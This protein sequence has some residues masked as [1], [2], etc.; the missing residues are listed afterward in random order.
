MTFAHRIKQEI[1][2]NKMSID[3]SKALIIGVCFSIGYKKNNLYILK[4]KN[5]VISSSIKKILKKIGISITKEPVAHNNW[6]QFNTSYLPKLFIPKKH[7]SQFAA[8][9]FLGG[10]SISDSSSSAYHLE[11]RINDNNN[12]Q[13]ILDFFKKYKFDFNTINRANHSIIY[14][15]KS[16]VISDFLRAIRSYG[17]VMEFED[18]RISRDFNNNINRIANLEVHNQYKIAQASM[19]Q[20]QLFKQMKANGKYDVLK[21]HYKQLIELRLQNQFISLSELSALYNEKYKAHTTKS[22]IANWIQTI[23]KKN[24]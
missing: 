8:G 2:N 4:I 7:I 1:L 9:L 20:I 18:F 17:G 13:P 3:Q 21:K 14:I 24:S 10:G 6:I 23:K 12:V 15:K 19:N 11:I 16:D 22:I 5:N